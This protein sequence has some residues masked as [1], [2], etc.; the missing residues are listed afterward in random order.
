MMALANTRRI[1][2]L[3]GGG[4]AALEWLTAHRLLFPLILL[5]L[6]FSNSFYGLGGILVGLLWLALRVTRCVESERGANRAALSRE[7]NFL[8]LR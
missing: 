4:A 8:E 7:V 2:N 5:F 3:L 6:V 1:L